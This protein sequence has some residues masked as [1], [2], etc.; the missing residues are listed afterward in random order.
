VDAVRVQ[1]LSPL[2]LD[3]KPELLFG[4]AEQTRQVNLVLMEEPE[5]IVYILH[6]AQLLVL[7]I[8]LVVEWTVFLPNALRYRLNLNN[9]FLETWILFCRFL[10]SHYSR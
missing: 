2:I 3:N 6:P 1:S 5:A 8:I 9:Y 10:V 7:L 4:L